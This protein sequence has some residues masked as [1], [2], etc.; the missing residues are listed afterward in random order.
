MAKFM[1]VEWPVWILLQQDRRY[2]AQNL[3]EEVK[4]TEQFGKNTY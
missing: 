4:L 1:R 2:I 3:Q